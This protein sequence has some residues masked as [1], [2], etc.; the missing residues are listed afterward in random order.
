MLS[1]TD[2]TP[3]QVAIPQHFPLYR[4]VNKSPMPASGN[5]VLETMHGDDKGHRA[6]GTESF[7]STAQYYN[8]IET[9]FAATLKSNLPYTGA[10]IGAREA[11]W[12]FCRAFAQTP[13]KD[14]A[15]LLQ[16]I[17]RPNAGKDFASRLPPVQG[18]PTGRI[19]F[20]AVINAHPLA[21]APRG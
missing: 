3:C 14:Y 7:S 16:E 8:P 21:G 4:Q 10:F 9:V 6:R 11:A 15:H 19:R 17:L 5:G 1:E 20:P 18:W 12:I 2:S 13:Q